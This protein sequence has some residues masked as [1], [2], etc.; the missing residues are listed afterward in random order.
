MIKKEVRVLKE[1]GESS[2]E[3]EKEIITLASRY[4]TLLKPVHFLYDNVFKKNYSI[5]DNGLSAM[6]QDCILEAR[7]WMKH[8]PDKFLKN[9]TLPIVIE[10]V[11]D[12]NK[13]VRLTAMQVFMSVLQND[14]NKDALRPNIKK[15]VVVICGR[16]LDKDINNSVYAIDI[17]CYADK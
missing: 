2:E 4:K 5:P 14:K 1:E 7:Q 17:L 3:L 9:D 15:F 16:I 13:N 11:T 12:M 10:A 6:R 8:L